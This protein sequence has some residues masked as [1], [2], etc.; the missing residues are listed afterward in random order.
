LTLTSPARRR[1]SR[2][3]T[4]G[5]DGL[6]NLAQQVPSRNQDDRP[7]GVAPSLIVVHGISLPPG[8]FE[9]D[10]IERLF[11]NRIDPSAHPYFATIADLRVSAHFLIRRSGSLLQFVACGQRAWHAGQSAWRGRSRCNDFSIGIELEGVDDVPYET[12][13]YTML[14]R[15]IDALHS[16]YPIEDVVGHSDV[17]PGRKTDPGR[18]FQWMRLSRLLARRDAHALAARVASLH[19]TR[20]HA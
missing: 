17:A 2:T 8:Q 15:L 10:G 7:Q 20:S 12:R 4:I 5:A 16:R 18:A 6:A 19:L 14:A 1:G 3:L 13:Q 9:G 11:T